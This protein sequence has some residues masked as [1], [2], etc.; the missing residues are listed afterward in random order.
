[1][2]K[3]LWKFPIKE[4]TCNSTPAVLHD[5]IYIGSADDAQHGRLYAIEAST[6]KEIWNTK[7]GGVDVAS[8]AVAHGLV[9]MSCLDSNVYAIDT[10][11]GAV[12]WT[13]SAYGESDNSIHSS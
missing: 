10:T 11:T 5:V 4:R 2:G 13:F 7:I 8:P 9:Y 3:L 1:T 12:R 6:G